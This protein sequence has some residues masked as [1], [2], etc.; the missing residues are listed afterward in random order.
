MN[1]HDD[2]DEKEEK[3]D[4]RHCRSVIDREVYSRSRSAKQTHICTPFE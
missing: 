4:E 1:R 3:G 2:D